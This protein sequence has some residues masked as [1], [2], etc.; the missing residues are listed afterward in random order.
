MTSS[1]PTAGCL[2][3]VGLAEPCGPDPDKAPC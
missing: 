2:P 3:P 1:E